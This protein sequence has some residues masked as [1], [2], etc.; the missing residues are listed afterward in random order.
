MDSFVS[1]A[2]NQFLI[3]VHIL[4]WW[5]LILVLLKK[6][7]PIACRWTAKK[8]K[9]L[10]SVAHSLWYDNDK[11]WWGVTSNIDLGLSTSSR[12]DVT[13]PDP[14]N[15]KLCSVQTPQRFQ[16]RMGTVHW[17]LL[18]FLWCYAALIARSNSFNSNSKFYRTR[19]Q[20]SYWFDVF[21]RA[22]VW[23]Q[24]QFSS[25]KVRKVVES[26]ASLAPLTYSFI[27]FAPIRMLIIE[28]RQKKTNANTRHAAKFISVTDNNGELHVLVSLSHVSRSQHFRY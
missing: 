16:L 4:F 7:N 24:Y 15:W 5:R 17:S 22:A 9:K 18:Y 3:W 21:D 27:E 25:L 1:L 19:C 8:E 12:T 14:L 28:R 10:T 20:L 6:N 2:S 13:A 11:D 23:Q 26:S